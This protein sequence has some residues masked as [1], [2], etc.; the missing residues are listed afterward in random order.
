MNN[1]L[2]RLLWAALIC[3]APAEAKAQPYLQR[4][5]HPFQ[6]SAD[7]THH[8]AWRGPDGKFFCSEFCASS[9]DEAELFIEPR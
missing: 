4:Q 5:G 8:E 6:M 2:R 3:L 9:A 7:G 1:L